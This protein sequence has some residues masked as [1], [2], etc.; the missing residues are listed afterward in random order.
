MGGGVDG[1]GRSQ[2]GSLLRRDLNADLLRN[3]ARHLALQ[4]QHVGQRA[5][6]IPGPQMGIGRP[7][8]QLD[9]DLHPPVLA[10]HRTFNDTI[11]F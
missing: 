7:M 11:Y 3:G 5:L 1:G 4:L 8:N 6:V 2:P 10:L 9:H